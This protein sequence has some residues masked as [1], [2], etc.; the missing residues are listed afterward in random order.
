MEA[1]RAGLEVSTHRVKAVVKQA[2]KQLE[3]FAVVGRLN[4]VEI[5]QR[6]PCYRTIVIE[7]PNESRVLQYK[8]CR[9]EAIENSK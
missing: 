5:F 1:L 4:A 2:D 9:I 7:L 6:P 3:L 8:N